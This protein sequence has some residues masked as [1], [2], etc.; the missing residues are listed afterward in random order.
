MPHM[1]SVDAHCERSTSRALLC[2]SH[3]R[4]RRRTFADGAANFASSLRDLV[5][6]AMLSTPRQCVKAI[7]AL[8]LLWT[9]YN[10]VTSSRSNQTLP[11][12]SQQ[13]RDELATRREAVAAAFD[14]AW[15]GY[16]THCFGH[17]A[18]HPVSNTCSDEL[19][20]WGASAIDALSTAILLDRQDAVRQILRFVATLDFTVVQGGGR[21]QV[22]EVIIRHLAGLISAN[23]LLNGPYG[24]LVPE[25]ELRSSLFDQM[26][27]LGD[28]LTCA[29]DAT[30][31]VPR[32]SLDPKTC[33]TDDA[34]T[35]TVAAV[36]TT[37]LEFA[38][39]SAVTGN[40]TYVKLA[41]RAEAYLLEPRPAAREVWPGILGSSV[42]VADGSLL[43]VHGS[44]GSLAD[45]ELRGLLFI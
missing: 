1:Q 41:R 23:D 27:R 25:K 4:S 30:S 36:G 7:L 24:H 17:D 20:G 22:F 33:T 37:I 44:W 31:G 14:H 13:R 8:G 38:R 40:E 3:N 10:H 16:A 9:I 29:F 2:Q 6:N 28:I 18:L 34:E 21:I 32:N 19:G 35:S 45:C 26:V 12:A 15:M 11:T 42:A 43:D 5:S 39:L